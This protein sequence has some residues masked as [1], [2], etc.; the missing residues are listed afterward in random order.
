MKVGSS[1]GLYGFLKE[2]DYEYNVE[3]KYDW[4]ENDF[5]NYAL[6]SEDD[7][8]IIIDMKNF[9]SYCHLMRIMKYVVAF[10]MD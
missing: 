1:D 7:C 9:K 5:E 6:V 8:P 2:T 4:I 3:F 10:T